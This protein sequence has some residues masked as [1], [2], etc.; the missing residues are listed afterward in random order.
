MLPAILGLVASVSAPTALAADDD[1]DLEL[2]GYYR[3][4]GYSFSPIDQ[5]MDEWGSVMVQRLRIQPQINFEDKAKFVMMADLI[6]DVAWGDNSSLMPASIF[7]QDPSFTRMEGVS[8]DFFGRSTSTAIIKRAWME[9]D[10]PIGVVRVGRQ[11]SN[12]GMGILS[13]NGNGFDDKFGENHYGST[14]DRVMFATRPIA[15][16]QGL[17]GRKDTGIP[18][19]M[20]V[21][22]DRLV[23]DPLDEY[24]GYQCSLENASGDRITDESP[25][26]DPRC[27]NEDLVTAQPGKDGIHDTEHDYVNDE[28]P[29]AARND[30]WFGDN[31]DDAWEMVYV[32][33]Y[34]GEDLPWLGNT[35]D[36]TLGAYV[37]DRRHVESN[38]RVMI[39]DAYT[40]F[41]HRGIY[42]EGEAVNIRGK[43]SGLAL[44]GTYDPASKLSNPL[45]KDANIWG[46]AA[47]A[48]YKKKK[49]EVILE[50][51]HA[52][53]DENVADDQFTVR[54][55][56]PDYNV[57]LLLF[58]EIMSRVTQ[59]TWGD[60]AYA[61]W[62]NGGVWNATYLYPNV[63]VR[64][65]DDL[66]VTG[67]Y[68]LAWPHKPDG[69][70]ILCEEADDVECVD[71]AG[72]TLAQEIGYEVDL[73]VKYRFHEHV[74]FS[75]EGGYAKVSNRVPLEDLGLRAD[76]KFF[77]VQSRIAYE[78]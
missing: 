10:V 78:F 17:T 28:R 66:E 26:Y 15:V 37:I 45:Y 43:T 12:W 57:G 6:D 30:V 22:V 14:F 4:R 51:G 68:V 76:G 1:W 63:T 31:D 39:Y 49:L 52:S 11:E 44:P 75:L 60:E 50:A 29:E 46:W 34:R 38:S 42:V 67:A 41:H 64:P 25:D 71:P 40:R 65:V 53:G 5:D 3:T 54:A 56:H 18:F 20:A 59:R 61:L 74:L 70:R 13:N 23:E 62:S 36:F 2:E 77:T 48:G 27:D 35:G 21:G 7:A 55:L 58:E 73:A 33:I 47:R 69:S 24:Y 72:E 32:A 9:F 16:I 8:Q 19:F